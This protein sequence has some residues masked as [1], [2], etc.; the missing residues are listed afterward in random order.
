MERDGG[1]TGTGAV[2][3][4]SNPAGGRSAGGLSDAPAGGIA[5]VTAAAEKPVRSL[6]GCGA[7][8]G[9]P[10]EQ[11]NQAI[12]MLRFMPGVALLEVSQFMETRPVGGPPGQPAYLN[13]ACLIETSFEPEELLAMLAAIENT[14]DRRREQRW[15]P[16]SIDLDLLLHG[17]RIIE[18]ER[19]QLPHPRMTTRRFVLE[20]A[21]EIASDLRHPQAGCTIGDLLENISQR[22]LHVAVVGIPGSGC[23]EVASAVAD[24]TLSRQLHAPAALP[25]AGGPDGTAA[26]ATAFWQETLRQYAAP[27]KR[28]GWPGD[29]HGTVADYWLET[30]RL[31]AERCLAPAG[32]R[33]FLTAFDRLAAGTVPPHIVLFLEVG[34]D[35]LRERISYCRQPIRQSD[36]FADLVC[37]GLPETSEAE[38]LLALQDD[39]K[40]CLTGGS[41]PRPKAV[42]RFDADDLGRTV[43]EAVAAIEAI[44]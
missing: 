39:L 10:R 24:V 21:A 44:Q 19:L 29:P 25:I 5:T 1:V 34:R 26:E 15:G 2:R 14:L 37:S 9:C 8:L 42:I 33:E 11:L 32:R 16:R 41:A 28:S 22:H 20:P 4:P 40:C 18:N 35:A 6:I 7:N 17:D 38:A 27:L 43:N 36:V 31:A 13:A 3:P 30:V 23:P 12:D